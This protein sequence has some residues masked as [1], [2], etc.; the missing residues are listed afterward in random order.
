[1]KKII[2]FAALALILGPLTHV[3]FADESFK[4]LPE[5][6]SSPLMFKTIDPKETKNDGAKDAKND[7]AE[8][9]TEKSGSGSAM[10]PTPAP[11]SPLVI[12]KT[13][14]TS[15]TRNWE[16]AIEKTANQTVN[17]LSL[18]TLS[19]SDSEK[20]TYRIV[21]TAVAKDSNYMVSGVISIKN[22]STE[23][24]SIL[25]IQD[26]MDSGSVTVDCGITPVSGYTLA[27]GKSL[28]CTYNTQSSLSDTTNT[29]NVIYSIGI[30]A[31][32]LNISKPVDVIWGSPTEEKDVCIF[33]TDSHSKG[34]QGLKH[35]INGTKINTYDLTFSREGSNRD[36]TLECGPNNKFTNTV[37]FVGADTKQRG[38]TSVDVTA[39]VNCDTNSGS[40]GGGGGGGTIFPI[41][42]PASTPPAASGDSS[43]QQ[44]LGEQFF[45][46]D[47]SDQQVL[48]EQVFATTSV[49]GS[50]DTTS[51]AFPKTGFGPETNNHAIA[52]QLS[53]ALFLSALL[54]STVVSRK[55][56]PTLK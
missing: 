12:T 22:Q 26:E 41:I 20:V 37:S 16:W 7:P 3:S 43:D 36:E 34:P 8:V 27:P 52:W 50:T 55:A 48:G 33:V 32:K 46:G 28:D 44:V 1:M 31:N 19:P 13:A 11:S 10:V 9:T 56:I 17:T 25:D 38:E 49:D 14:V 45:P 47:S 30:N 6:E 29:V 53:I 54:F 4:T 40:G 15:F 35:C 42:T 21:P 24:V 5:A 23:P 2:I 39:N 18:G 51:P